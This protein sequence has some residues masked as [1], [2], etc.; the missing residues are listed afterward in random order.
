MTEPVGETPTPDE[1]TTHSDY[2]LRLAEQYSTLIVCV[3]TD[4]AA[5]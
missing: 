4:V 5:L 3:F 2:V 1:Q